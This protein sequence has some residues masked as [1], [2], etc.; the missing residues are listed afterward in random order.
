MAAPSSSRQGPARPRLERKT[1]KTASSNFSQMWPDELN[2][3]WE[4]KNQRWRQ[5]N[6]HGTGAARNR[7]PGWSIGNCPESW[8]TLIN[9]H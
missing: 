5:W 8:N 2:V 1:P 4:E 7:G 3:S 6:T 9:R